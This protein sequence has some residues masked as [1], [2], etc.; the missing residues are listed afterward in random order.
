MLHSKNE[1]LAV[2]LEKYQSGGD[3]DAEHT[4]SS[5]AGSP[6]TNGNGPVEISRGTAGE[7]NAT[8][9][10]MKVMKQ[11]LTRADEKMKEVQATMSETQ[12]E[13]QRARQRERLNEDHSARLTATV[14]WIS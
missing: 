14:S 1:D 13:L 5:T 3:A 4:V 2:Q 10:S 12:A 7:A 11:E 9:D 6:Q 8:A